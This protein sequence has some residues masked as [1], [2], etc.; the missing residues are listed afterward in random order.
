MK[1]LLLDVGNS[2]LKWGIAERGELVRTGHIA[3][4]KIRDQGLGV[5]TKRLPR[6]VDAVMASNVAGPTY[7]TRLAGLVHAH[8][9]RDLHFAK[10]ARAAF[11][12]TSSYAQPRRMGVDR[13]VAMIGA[14]A[15]FS[16]ACVIV[17]A[18]T[19][20]TI[21]ALDKSGRHL[22]GQILPG[23]RLM[24]QALHSETS[25]LPLATSPRGADYHGLSM[26]ASTT[27]D[28]ISSGALNAVTGAVERAVRTLRSKAY[29]P[30]LV[31]TGGDASRILQA[32]DGKPVHRPHLVLQGLLHMLTAEP[33]THR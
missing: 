8:C 23:V 25:D 7:A 21:D 4:Q 16:S 18:G 32:L 6:H 28:A 19:A 1:A 14:R 33:T 2:R 15:E 22:G 29:R 31:L 13:W 30:R 5:L 26:F 3:Q 20:V 10:T 27:R 11:G 9:D 17:D 24:A 12:V